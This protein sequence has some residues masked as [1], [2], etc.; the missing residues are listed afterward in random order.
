MAYESIAH[1][2]QVRARARGIIVNYD[3]LLVIGDLHPSP[4]SYMSA[5]YLSE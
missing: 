4:C 3:F 1:E 2:A 5:G